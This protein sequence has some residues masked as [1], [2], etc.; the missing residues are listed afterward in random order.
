MT[1]RAAGRITLAAGHT[2]ERDA[3]NKKRQLL[4]DLSI[5][6]VLGKAKS[7]WKRVS[8]FTRSLDGKYFGSKGMFNAYRAAAA[9]KD[10]AAVDQAV[11]DVLAQN[12]PSY[13]K[14]IEVEELMHAFTG[15]VYAEALTARNAYRWLDPSELQSYLNGTFMSKAEGDGTRR[16]FK[17]L[18]MNRNLN[19][20][21]RKVM[22]TVPLDPD[23]RRSLRRVHYT[24]LPRYIGEK[25]ERIGDPKNAANAGE[26][27]VRVPDGTAVPPGSV[28]VVKPGTPMSG[29]VV[30][31]LARKY[32]VTW[33]GVR[34]GG[35][36]VRR[37][38]LL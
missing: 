21:S 14:F 24:A 7:A 29:D 26:A 22:I 19:F 32:T 31:A 16:G 35:H 33:Q 3:V 13:D 25:N 2:I 20:L 12:R 38:T 1:A 23:I 11:L 17:A 5:K 34:H 27:E 36:P 28:F 8:P 9:R 15:R 37:G 10:W 18:S 6:A 30:R 4:D